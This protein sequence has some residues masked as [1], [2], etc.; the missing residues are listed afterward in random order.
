MESRKDSIEYHQRHKKMHLDVMALKNT[1][2]V[3]K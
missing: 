2:Q 3:H 1:R